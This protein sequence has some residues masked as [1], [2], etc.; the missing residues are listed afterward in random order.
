MRK[1]ELYAVIYHPRPLY[2]AGMRRWLERHQELPS[3]IVAET[4][5]FV[6]LVRVLE[7]E[8]A[9]IVVMPASVL[10]LFIEHVRESHGYHDQG[11]SGIGRLLSDREKK[12]LSYF[13]AGASRRELCVLLGVSRGSVRWFTE[14]IFR[15]LQVH[16]RT[17]AVVIA[18]QYGVITWNDIRCAEEELEEIRKSAPKERKNVTLPALAREPADPRR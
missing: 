10:K 6:Q 3:K 16:D 14:I 2:L 17:A 9:D 8:W 11:S 12:I 5:D 4:G 1:D 15:K 18:L 13:A 7:R